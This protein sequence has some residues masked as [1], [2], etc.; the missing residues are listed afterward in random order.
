MTSS[1]AGYDAAWNVT[2]KPLHLLH[3]CIT[4]FPAGLSASDHP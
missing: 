4:L 3:C 2:V 1:S